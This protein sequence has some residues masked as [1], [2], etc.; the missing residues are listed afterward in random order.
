MSYAADD[1]EAI[2][3]RL[4]M[5]IVHGDLTDETIGLVDQLDPDDLALPMIHLVRYVQGMNM[6]PRLRASINRDLL[7]ELRIITIEQS[8]DLYPP[9]PNEYLPTWRPD[10][11]IPDRVL[12]IIKDLLLEILQGRISYETLTAIDDLGELEDVPEPY[13]EML[14]L[15]QSWREDGQEIADLLIYSL[16][17]TIEELKKLRR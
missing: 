10:A 5:D 16:S 7:D 11:P 17:W 3:G 14:S 13:Q 1:Q 15:A 6:S 12:P 2:L 8:E 4:L 9:D